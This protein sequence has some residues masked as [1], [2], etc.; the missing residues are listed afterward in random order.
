MPGCDA[1]AAPGALSF[2]LAQ[3]P[4]SI[5]IPFS[6]E[7]Q[8]TAILRVFF[9]RMTM[10]RLSQR[11]VSAVVLFGV[12]FAT[13]S[14]PFHSQAQ[15]RNKPASRQPD[16]AS[17]KI[18]F[19]KYCGSCH[20]EDG[21]GNGPTAKVLTPPPT[22]LTTLSK[23]HEGKY[24]AS[25]ISALLKFGRNLAAHGSPDMPVWGSQ[26]KAI[27]PT[28]DPTGQRHIDDV[29]AYLQSIQVK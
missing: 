5:S 19:A 11:A 15:S 16:V 6:L 2:Q 18:T 22:D 1:F 28:G 25:Y 21:K 8:R 7:L 26:F 14:S 29:V 23:T 3:R 20:G 10:N 9:T 27:D 24:P 12:V 17:G 13:A 4:F